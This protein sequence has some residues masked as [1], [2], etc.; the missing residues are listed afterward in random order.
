MNV[1]EL[2]QVLE[3]ILNEH[4]DIRVVTP[5]FDEAGYDD[6]EEAEVLTLA[7]DV[8]PAGGHSGSHED[9]HDAPPGWQQEKVV[10]INFS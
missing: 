2:I 9:V 6:V 5:G 1:R 10:N 3:A 7:I 8:R 4:G